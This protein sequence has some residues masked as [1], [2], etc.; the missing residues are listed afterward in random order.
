MSSSKNILK[1]VLTDL[2]S[3]SSLGVTFLAPNGDILY[4]SFTNEEYENLAAN[5]VKRSFSSMDVSDFIRRG[6]ADLNLELFVFK[7]SNNIMVSLITSEPIGTVMVNL[8][9]IIRKYQKEL[10]SAFQSYNILRE[11]FEEPIDHEVHEIQD[12]VLCKTIRKMFEKIKQLGTIEILFFEGDK[13]IYGS[14]ADKEYEKIA[15]DMVIKHI[16]DLNI[17]DF[18]KKTLETDTKLFVCK[19]S[20]TITTA[21]LAKGVLGQI[22]LRLK[23]IIKE[24][25]SQLDEI[26]N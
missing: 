12:E 6:L 1:N 26:F 8:N 3:L 25:G 24:F 15:I 4:G 14:F 22:L 10:E 17:S 11:V 20:E 18:I 21:F 9:I 13:L 5:I 19:L 16:S 7:I 23:E 2:E